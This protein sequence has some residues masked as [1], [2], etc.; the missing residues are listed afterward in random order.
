[1]I[2]SADPQKARTQLNWEAQYQM[3]DVVRMMVEAELEAR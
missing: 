3:E 1:M 2:S